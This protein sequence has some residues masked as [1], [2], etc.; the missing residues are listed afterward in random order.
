M[1]E[2]TA[3]FQERGDIN[4]IF[5]KDPI[6]LSHNLR[7]DFVT[8]I[9]QTRNRGIQQDLPH[10]KY[11]ACGDPQSTNRYVT[12]GR[13]DRHVPNFQKEKPFHGIRRGRGKLSV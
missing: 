11:L 4:T 10:G 8:A 9:D 1:V 5:H 2:P 3:F 6:D 7:H 13:R 12:F